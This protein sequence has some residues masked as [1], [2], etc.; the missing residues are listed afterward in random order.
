MII[1]SSVMNGLEGQLKDRIL[2]SVPQVIVTPNQPLQNWQSFIDEVKQLDKV[3]AVS[4]LVQT[5]AMIQSSNGLSGAQ[6]YGIDPDYGQEAQLLD[7]KLIQGDLS[8]L[9]AGEYGVFLGADMARNLDV[10]LG[11]KVRLYSGK[12]VMFSPLG[13]VPS[14]RNF[15]VVGLFKM[16]SVVDGALAFVHY[17]DGARL[18]RKNP[19]QL[20]SLR[21]FL[22]DPFQ[23]NQ[24][25]EQ[26]KQTFDEV[27]VDDWHRNYG[28]LFAAVKMEKRMMSLMLSLIV[29]VAAFNIVSAL[30][31]MVVDKSADIAILKTQGVT[32]PY[33]MAIFV[34]QGMLNSIIG[35]IIGCAIGLLLAFNL[36]TLLSELGLSLL[37]PGVVLPVL[38]VPQQI[39]AIVVGTILVSLLATIY[40]AI[41]AAQIQPAETLRYE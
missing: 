3:V 11:D 17:A 26:L 30:V 12:G 8:L 32:T 40:P 10:G 20:H 28:H 31:M 7:G 21:L 27:T 6:L 14:Q 4:P 15:R 25:S 37:G 2:G 33:A 29:A 41:K 35:L 18:M 1:V 13:P 34:V 9:T 23:A 24:V 39:S 36:T 38:I 5:Q 16:G 19:A 22:E